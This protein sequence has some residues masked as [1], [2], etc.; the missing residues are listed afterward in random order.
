MLFLGQ[1]CAPRFQDNFH[2][3]MFEP[4]V[5]LHRLIGLEKYVP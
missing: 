1:L 3:K 5:K 2:L 4:I